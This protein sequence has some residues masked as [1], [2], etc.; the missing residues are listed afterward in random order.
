MHRI[1]VAVVRRMGQAHHAQDKRD[2]D[3]GVQDAIE[4][5]PEAQDV[6]A[7]LVEL[8]KLVAD[9]TDGEDVEQHLGHVETAGRVGGVDGDGVEDEEAD[10]DQELG[11]VLVAGH[12]DAVGIEVG[13]E[14]DLVPV[15]VVDKG[16]GIV[17]VLD[18]PAAP[19]VVDAFLV[20]RGGDDVDGVEVNGPFDDV[21]GIRGLAVDKDGV[22]PKQNVVEEER[23]VVLG[24]DSVR[25]CVSESQFTVL[26]LCRE[27]ISIGDAQLA[28][29]D[30]GG[31]FSAAVQLG[32]PQLGG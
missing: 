32:I 18:Q 7:G 3:E 14:A 22:A 31:N 26:C 30:F 2:G 27:G 25:T 10:G 21:G 13:E 17:L 24:L 12:A 28:C 23:G 1:L 29:N 20:T 8:S 6:V 11:G 16:G 5:G 9:E 15:G 19:E 4:G